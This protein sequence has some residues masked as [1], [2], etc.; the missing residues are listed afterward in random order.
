LAERSTVVPETLAPRLILPL[1]AVVDNDSVLVAVITPEVVNP[2]LLDTDTLLPVEVPL[3]TLRAVPA[4]PTQVTFP[5]VLN[6][7][8]LVDPVNVLISPEPE[9]RFKLVAVTEPPV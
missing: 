5:E 6:V 8:L 4:E 9:L 2:A 3:P 1:L 7:R